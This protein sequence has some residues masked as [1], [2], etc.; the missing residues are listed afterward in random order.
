MRQLLEHSLHLEALSLLATAREEDS[1]EVESAY[2][3]GWSWFLRAEAIE[4]DPSLVLE[5]EDNEA[6]EEETGS[7]NMSAKECYEESMRALLECAKS[8]AEQD[9][10]DDGIGGHVKE[11]LEDLGA[12]GIKAPV[13]EDEAGENGDGVEW[14]DVDEVEQEDVE[15]A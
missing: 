5:I 3:E 4:A 13:V 11:L 15:M 12:K 6:G 8:F 10:P 1:L 7:E 2:L 9:Y 14:E